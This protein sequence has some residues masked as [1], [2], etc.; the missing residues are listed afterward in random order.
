M[1]RWN[2]VGGKVEKLEWPEEAAIRETKEEIGVEIRKLSQVA[3]I[4]FYF[5]LIEVEKDWNQQVV[6]YFAYK[7]KGEITESE[8]MRPKW[9][10][11]KKL[12]YDLMWSD[13]RYWL[14]M[15][16]NN[17]RVGGEFVF[18]EK[19]SVLEMSLTAKPSKHPIK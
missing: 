4:D 11:Q 1:G 2:G 3:V 19:D 13:D 15:V 5:P 8:E 16:L 7:W 12:P 17:Y 9:F 6:I 14:P 18:G 10:S